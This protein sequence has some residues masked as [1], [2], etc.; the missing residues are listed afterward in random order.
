MKKLVHG[1]GINDADYNVQ[2]FEH[3]GYVDGKRKQRL[4]WICPYYLTWKSM[5]ERGYSSKFKDKWTTYKDVFVNEDWH[6][7]SNF[8]NWMQ[9]QKWQDREG[10]KLYLDKDLLFIGNKEYSKDK[11]VFIPCKVNNFVTDSRAKRGEWPLGVS[12]HKDSGKFIANCNVNGRQ[13]HLGL[14]SDP[15]EAHLTWKSYK[16]NLSLQY[17]NELE[18]E[19]YDQRLIQALRTRY[20]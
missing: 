7:F 2:Q 11:C 12:W 19:G 5:L 18:F 8:R 17:A 15:N 16:H 9:E 20:L 1:I 3:L 13:F 14:F 4:V 10:N 6:L